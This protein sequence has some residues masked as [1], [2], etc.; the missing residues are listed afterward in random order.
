M[1]RKPLI[2]RPQALNLRLSSSAYIKLAAFLYSD[3]E[4]RIPKGAWARF[5]TER[6][7]EFF[8]ERR[9]DLHPY[10]MPAGFFVRGPKAMIEQLELKLQVTH[11][12]Y[13]RGYTAG[14]ASERKFPHRE[15]M[16]R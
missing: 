2:D 3:V 6:V 15:D 10:G 9:L 4:A 16:G 11:T 1:P 12:A 5:F 7:E 13:S 14:A 8:G